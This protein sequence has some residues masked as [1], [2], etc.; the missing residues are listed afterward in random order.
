MVARALGLRRARA[1]LGAAL[2]ANSVA[3]AA[4]AQ[5][6]E[7]AADAIRFHHHPS[8]SLATP[9][10]DAFVNENGTPRINQPA[11]YEHFKRELA[12][13]LIEWAADPRINLNPAYV[14]ALLTKESGF[15]LTATSNVPA[16][17]LAQITHIADLDLRIITE[18]VPDLAWMHREVSRWPRD[19]HVHTEHATKARTDSL[20]S[21]GALHARNEYLLNG[22]QS[23]RAALFWLHILGRVWTEDEW[24]GEYGREARELLNDGRPLSESQLLDLV[25]VSYNQGHPYVFE[26][27]ERHRGEWT[28]HLNEEAADY[29]ERIRA[30]TLLY[31]ESRN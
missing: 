23:L 9:P 8:L 6:R 20:V 4:V 26:L 12:P 11:A 13:R 15:E 25:T 28:R 18:G 2:T 31:Q 24:P 22:E 19:A 3:C 29:L 16:N 17:G 14:A 5:Q 30:Y 10:A 7:P 27:V 1:I 21:S